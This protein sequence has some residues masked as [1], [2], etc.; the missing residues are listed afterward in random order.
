MMVS[1]AG[2]EGSAEKALFGQLSDYPQA[3]GMA[4]FVMAI[5]A[6]LPGMPHLVFLVLAAG[7]GALAY[8][9]M[10]SARKRRALETARKDAGKGRDHRR[11]TS[12]SRPRSRSICCASN[13]AMGFCR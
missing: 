2:V 8:A 6:V 11:P 1:K 4:A 5:M 9:R 13:S 10:A 12:R 7:A 3:L